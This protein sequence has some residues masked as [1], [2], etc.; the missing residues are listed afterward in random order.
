MRWTSGP[1]HR[2][3]GQIKCA[4]CTMRA[5]VCTL[6]VGVA[7]CAPPALALTRYRR[8]PVPTHIRPVV[9]TSLWHLS[10]S[11]VLLLSELFIFIHS[12]HVAYDI[13]LIA[14]VDYQIFF[15]FVD[16][17]AYRYTP[18]LLA[19]DSCRHQLPWN[20]PEFLRLIRTPL[21]QAAWSHHLVRHPDKEFVR[22]IMEGMCFGFR[23]G[24]DHVRYSCVR[25]RGNMA[26][27]RQDSNL[28][29]SYLDEERS[30]GKVW[31]HPPVAVYYTHEFWCDNPTRIGGQACVHSKIKGNYLTGKS[32]Q[33]VVFKTTPNTEYNSNNLS[34]L[35]SQ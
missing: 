19:L 35:L 2:T 20:L 33:K 27:T 16:S 17:V 7:M 28:V 9:L 25:A 32:A 13:V 24:F 6:S 10:D 3:R 21:K 34:V 26:S 23:L 31:D 5:S 30:L 8:V 15:C 29:S 11:G 14:C 18:H 12:S 4:F 22:Y 1:T